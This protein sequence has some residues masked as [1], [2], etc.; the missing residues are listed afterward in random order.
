MR[1]S[2]PPNLS[3]FSFEKFPNSLFLEGPAGCGKTTAASSH[4]HAL[5]ES[6]VPGSSILVLTPQRTL[7][8]PFELA[9]RS[10]QFADGSLPT[11]LTFAGLVRRLIDLFWPLAAAPA[12]FRSPD[13]PPVFLTIET[14]QYYMSHLVRPLLDEKRLFESVVIDRNRIYGQVLDSLNKSAVVGFPASEIGEKLKAA[15]VGSPGQLRIYGDVQ[16]CA[17]AFRGYCLEHN[18]LDFSLQM[19]VFRDHLWNQPACRAFLQQNWLHLIADNLEEETPFAHDLL[20]DWLPDFDS[21]FLVYDWKAGYRRF[22][23]A[24]PRSAYRLKSACLQSE[25]L[26]TT[27]VQPDHL[28]KLSSQLDQAFASPGGSHFLF[29]GS[30]TELPGPP[31]KPA[32]LENAEK[33]SLQLS[34]RRFFPDMLA[35]AAEKAAWLVHTQGIPPAEIVILAPYLPDAMRFELYERLNALDVPVRSLR[36][37][38][39]LREEPATSCLLTLAALGH[40][41]WGVRPSRYDVAYALL[42]AVAD[43]DLVRA[44][45]LAEVVY[46]PQA[47]G[48]LLSSFDLI[49]ADMQARITYR[50][51]ERFEKLRLWLEEN[52]NQ[53]EELDHYLARLFGEVLSQ[54]GF[55]FHSRLDDG[56]VAANLIESIRKFRLA[57][58]GVL[59]QEGIPLGREYLHMVL[60][61]L[62]AAQYPGAWRWEDQNAVLVAPATTFL[63]VNQPVDV[64]I[65]LDIGSTSWAERLEQ[66]LTHPYVL[67]RGWPEGRVWSDMDEFETSRETLRRLAAGLLARCRAS[68]FL[69]LCELSEQG[70]DQRGPLLQAFQSLLRTRQVQIEAA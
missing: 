65:W 8:F 26:Q 47:E 41:D 57:A 51:G 62:I 5:I 70:Y 10:P 59:G 21:A 23:G 7:G 12:G 3:P 43:L 16:L 60:E 50:A 18:L 35:W 9:L 52:Q 2:P 69:G 31:R 45:V 61:G 44:Q 29:S 15:W 30:E 39:T 38:R 33:L 14:A 37:S 19:Q 6:G 42:Q 24:D 11:L 32:N 13:A 27:W 46:S 36:P 49:R 63:M 40:P 28:Q 68:L 20:L 34:S 66:P 53:A 4:L 22:L 67:S 48:A 55:G 25:V 17:D 58:G 64:Q 54:P 1:K 56:Q